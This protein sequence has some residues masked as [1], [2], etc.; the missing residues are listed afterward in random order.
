M[1]SV[2]GQRFGRVNTVVGE[3]DTVKEAPSPTDLV[4]FGNALLVYSDNLGTVTTVDTAK[5]TDIDSTGSQATTA[6]PSG[7]DTMVHSGDYVAYLTDAGQVMA[8]RVSNGSA[9]SPTQLDPFAS[10]TVVPRA[11]SGPSSARSR[12]PWPPTERS[13]RTRQSG[14]R[15]CAR[16]PPPGS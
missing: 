16:V 15:C 14:A 13:P 12:L 8:G 3:V 5:P 6:T 9:V 1:Q 11:R 2:A 7:T 4:Q 10:V